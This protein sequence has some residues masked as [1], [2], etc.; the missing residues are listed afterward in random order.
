MTG[1]VWT[2]R[3]LLKGALATLGL[4]GLA[5][6]LWW[7]RADPA[8]RRIKRQLSYLRLD[9]RGV[10][11]FLSDYAA[12]YGASRAETTEDSRLALHF[13]VSSDFFEHGADESRTIHY[14][15][16]Y[17]PYLSPCFNPFA[18]FD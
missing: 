17:D 5:S 4:G 2:R 15:R 11:D 18:R 14:V 3:G 8:L 10:R 12:A 7:R 13:L 16:L 6:V 9:R 1:K